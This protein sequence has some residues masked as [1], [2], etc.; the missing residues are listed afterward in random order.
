MLGICRRR[1]DLGRRLVGHVVFEIEGAQITSAIAGRFRIGDI[2]R[3]QILPRLMPAH[4]FR[5]RC[6]QRNLAEPHGRVT[7]ETSGQFVPPEWLTDS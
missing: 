4:L 1:R 6:E 5:H 2:L 3:E 7:P